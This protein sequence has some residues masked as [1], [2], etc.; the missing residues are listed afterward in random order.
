M[1]RENKSSEIELQIKNHFLDLFSKKGFSPKNNFDLNVWFMKNFDE[2]FDPRE[3]INRI[4]SVTPTENSDIV[5]NIIMKIY[6]KSNNKALTINVAEFVDELV[7]NYINFKS[8]YTR[9]IKL[10]RD[11]DAFETKSKLEY[12]INQNLKSI[13]YDDEFT[14]SFIAYLVEV[15]NLPKT[16]LQVSLMAAFSNFNNSNFK[17]KKEKERHSLK[18]SN[19]NN[20]NSSQF[21]TN[22]SISQSFKAEQVYEYRLNHILKNSEVNKIDFSYDN[23]YSF[24]NIE[25]YAFENTEQLT[26]FDSGTNFL[27]FFLKA[28]NLNNEFDEFMI[29]E[30]KPFLD[31]F[32]ANIKNIINNPFEKHKVFPLEL[33]L[34]NDV[35]NMEFVLKVIIE[36]DTN[37][38]SSIFVKIVNILQNIISF[39]IYVDEKIKT[40]YDYFPEIAK[41]I[42]D[43]FHQKKVEKGCNL[44]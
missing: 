38:Q 30:K 32:I 3:F 39:K 5:K 15:K 23:E 24:P 22:N 36:L 35:Y 9:I 19:L 18:N 37:T 14:S 6:L 16:D 7:E 34:K 43:E 8:E 40:I 27:Y 21:S 12:F 13:N 33:K 4:M 11:Y 41:E 17:L 1:E 20:L 28:E 26:K 42:D 25:F 44:F 31:L 10:I 29:S 2:D